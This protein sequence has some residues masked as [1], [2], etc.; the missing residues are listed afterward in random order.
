MYNQNIKWIRDKINELLSHLYPD[1]LHILCFTKHHLNHLE[2]KQ[3]YTDNYNL[4]T[5]YCRMSCE[6]GGECIY[7]YKGLNVFIII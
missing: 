6:K 1:L 7:V 3:T 5:K 4:G 2:L